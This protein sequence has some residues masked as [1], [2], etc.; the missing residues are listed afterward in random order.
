MSDQKSTPA[1]D[2]PPP[3]KDSTPGA[4]PDLSA[5]SDSPAWLSE[6]G[7]HD[8]GVWNRSFDAATDGETPAAEAAD[9]ETSAA[10]GDAGTEPIGDETAAVD[11]PAEPVVVAPDDL[12]LEEPS[13]AEP[14]LSDDAVEAAA[15]DQIASETAAAEADAA[16][17]GRLSGLEPAPAGAEIKVNTAG[18]APGADSES[19][20]GEAAASEN[21]APTADG[22][23]SAPEDKAPAT[24]EAALT[25]APEAGPDA[26]EPEENAAPAPDADKEPS[27]ADAEPHPLHG[28]NAAAP[29]TGAPLEGTDVS[30][31]APNE[32]EAV[33]AAVPAGETRRSR[34]LA[35]NRAAAGADRKQPVGAT[36]AGA[37]DPG[38]D[39]SPSGAG[40]IGATAKD[41]AG[42]KRNTRLLLVL[43]GV[44]LAAVI[45]ILLFVFV[46]NNKEEGVISED[47]SPVELEDG[48]CLRGWDD[49]NS[50][51]TV[52]TCETPH[53]AQLVAT[54]SF[55]ED[56]SF[57]GTAALEER[58]NEVCA[59]VDYSDAAADF[60]GLKLT[61]SIP[62]EQTWSSGDRRVDCIVFTA[63]DE[64][65]TESLLAG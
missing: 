37:T 38:A 2:F 1:A 60:P 53:N 45:A 33:T 22:D 56:A 44:V 35:E 4:F 18:T 54:D 28:I 64:E 58:V 21:E 63:E 17:A 61:K 24:D 29:M 41:G 12:K 6:D 59:A 26:L 52:V 19:T 16:E 51:A 9:G 27:A 55:T 34:R 25:S 30:A 11:L 3:E 42:N 46:F 14:A 10:D 57:P 8:A 32:P 15:L 5:H 20:G 62:T 43:G 40:T 31:A 7:S 47:V 65:L 39:H 23:T 36:E 50:S 48:A 49:V 13:L